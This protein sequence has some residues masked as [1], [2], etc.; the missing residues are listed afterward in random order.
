MPILNYTSKIPA[1][2]TAAE[3]QQ[4]LVAFGATSI[5]VDYDNRVPV[6]LSFTLDGLTKG[7][8]AFHAPFRLPTNAQ[9]VGEAMKRAKLTPSYLRPEH[10]Q[11]VA[12]RILKDWVEAQLAVMEAGLARP[13]QILL[14]FAVAPD[15]L[16]VYDH[17]D[18]DPSRLLSA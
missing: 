18:A 9:G 15:G 11:G 7:G 2:K 16:T 12:W 13:E 14:P 17:F 5:Q 10:V 1:E 3:I 6:A 8:R 4:R